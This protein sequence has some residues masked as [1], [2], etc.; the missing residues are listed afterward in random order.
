MQSRGS[1]CFPVG[2]NVAP[3][4]AHAAPSRA[5]LD[6]YSARVT[7]DGLA[8]ATRGLVKRYGTRPALAG[9][10]LSVPSG[11]VYGFLG[12][13]GAGKTAFV[14]SHV[15][16]EVEQL[17]DVIGIIASGRLVREGPI[18]QLLQGEG[19][20][21]VRVATDELEPARTALAALVPDGGVTQS[22]DDDG[23]LTVRIE[24]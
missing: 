6:R 12:P 17:A 19:E 18:E 4:P 20:V 5:R 24:D 11:V 10:D 15:L 3:P 21:R 13:N 14:S 9:L 8:L 22:G 2:P 1:R 16:G 7:T 23:W